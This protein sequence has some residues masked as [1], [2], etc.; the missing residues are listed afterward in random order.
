MTTL[1]MVDI[2]AIQSAKLL[3]LVW[4]LKSLILCRTCSFPGSTLIAVV[5][6]APINEQ[7]YNTQHLKKNKYYNNKVIIL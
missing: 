3:T 1:L 7:S 5:I 6:L 2:L 4:T